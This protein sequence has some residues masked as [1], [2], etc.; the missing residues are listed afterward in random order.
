M[1]KIA[2]VVLV[3]L[4]VGL[5]GCSETNQCESYSSE[6]P[7][8]QVYENAV[9]R[10]FSGSVLVR[11]KGD[12]LLNEAAGL[13]N[14]ELDIANSTDTIST[15]ESITKQYTGALILSLQQDGLLSVDDTLRDFF[16]NIPE[17]RPDISIHQLLTNSSGY[18]RSF[19][20]S[21][22]SADRDKFLESAWETTLRFEPGTGYL[23]SNIGYGIAAAVV[24]KVTGQ[25]YE[26]A[27]NERVLTPA[28]I[29][30]TGYV[31]PEWSDRV[32]A[33]GYAG[34]NVINL[35]ENRLTWSTEGGPS[36]NLL[37][38]NRLLTT[39]ADLL[40]WHDVLAGESVLNA[41]SID[42]LQGRHVATDRDGVSYGY[43]WNTLDTPAGVLH[44]NNESNGYHYSTMDRF[45]D[46]DLVIV[47]LANKTNE[48]SFCLP[49]ELAQASVS[50]LAGW[51][52]P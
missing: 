17:N 31:I 16:D 40:N 3:T 23:Y 50:K 9:E 21:F 2:K 18:P 28:L 33:N 45:I 41:N 32:I 7:V 25:S 42:L 12:V 8:S 11:Y 39:T 43:G 14:R 35:D 48:A 4:I 1:I 34:T 10:G 22:P 51:V 26:E 38:S 6:T 20:Q 44:H 47:M 52:S 13:A 36:W 30:D 19:G 15:M 24:E 27:L 49:Q 37:G 29:N 5:V 46:E